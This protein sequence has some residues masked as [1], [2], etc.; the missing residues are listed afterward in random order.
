MGLCGAFSVWAEEEYWRGAKRSAAVGEERVFLP[1]QIGY[2]RA[3]LP[4]QQLLEQPAL[5]RTRK[6]ARGQRP[7]SRTMS[8]T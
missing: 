4:R 1:R 6:S 5:R 2:H 7:D 8:R 3:V